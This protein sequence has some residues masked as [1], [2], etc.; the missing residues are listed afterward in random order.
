MLQVWDLRQNKLIYS[1]Q[2]HGDSVTGL[3]LSADGSYLLSNSM[4]NSGKPKCVFVHLC[5]HTTDQKFGVS[6]I[7]FYVFERS[8][9][10][11]QRLHLFDQ[12]YS[13]NINIVK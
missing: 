3:S 13:K 11:S 12:K 4:D 2:G 7:F 9:L 5:T 1:M 8:L 6:M 10:C